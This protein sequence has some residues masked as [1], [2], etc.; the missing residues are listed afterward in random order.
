M[1]LFFFLLGFLGLVPGFRPMLA[2]PLSINVEANGETTGGVR[3][4][5]IEADGTPSTAFA[6]S[7]SP[8]PG[9]HGAVPFPSGQSPAP[10][11]YEWFA[12][13]PGRYVASFVR[14]GGVVWVYAF[15]RAGERKTVTFE[16][17]GSLD[18]TGRVVDVEDR[19]PRRTLVSAVSQSL[20]LGEGVVFKGWDAVNADGRYTVPLVAAGPV[21]APGYVP[22]PGL[23]SRP[24]TRVQVYLDDDDPEVLAFNP[25]RE[26]LGARCTGDGDGWLL[27]GPILDVNL[28][29]DDPTSG[30]IDLGTHVVPT[31]TRSLTVEAPSSVEEVR[32]FAALRSFVGGFYLSAEELFPV[33]TASPGRTVS[34]LP[35]TLLV[36]VGQ[37]QG[38]IP[39]VGSSVKGATLQLEAPVG[40]SPPL[41]VNITGPPTAP[42]S[43]AVRTTRHVL[44][45]PA[46]YAGFVGTEFANLFAWPVSTSQLTVPDLLPG[47]Y[48]LALRPTVDF[49]FAGALTPALVGEITQAVQT[50]GVQLEGTPARSIDHPGTGPIDFTIAQ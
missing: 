42:A 41:Q 26:G 25:E 29:A 3:L 8:L 27:A 32:L 31:R 10:G 2:A 13:E 40:A 46:D 50:A 43:A 35:D 9:P 37:R 48:Q 30:R 17:P 49:V 12:L 7:A 45:L 20:A 15:A 21:H 14:P 44:V 16:N 5:L 11:V 36:A 6:L 38:K 33:G 4:R 24:A 1:R 23:Q 39:L 19:P 34:L 22:P 28:R 47:R 18:A